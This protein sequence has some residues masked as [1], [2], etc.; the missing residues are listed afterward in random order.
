[1]L[2]VVINTIGQSWLGKPQNTKVF[3]FVI[4]LSFGTNFPFPTKYE[5]K[6]LFPVNKRIMTEKSCLKRDKT[7]K[8]TKRQNIP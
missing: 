3:L 5:L 7:L 8:H 4:F 1:M 6:V 2:P